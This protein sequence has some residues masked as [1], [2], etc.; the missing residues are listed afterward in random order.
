MYRRKYEKYKAKYLA[1][2]KINVLKGGQ[3]ELPNCLLSGLFNQ[4]KGM[5]WMQSALASLF[6]SDEGR[7]YLWPQIYTFMEYTKDGKG[8]IKP[9]SIRKFS[10]EDPLNQYCLLFEIV[11]RNID[12]AY[13]IDIDAIDATDPNYR[14]EIKRNMSAGLCDE[15][16][17][18]LYYAIDPQFNFYYMTNQH[19]MK[20][21]ELKGG[22]SLHV[23]KRLQLA[24]NSPYDIDEINIEL[25]VTTDAISTLHDRNI[26]YDIL[27]IALYWEE[28]SHAISIFKCNGDFYIFDND[29][30][31]YSKFTRISNEYLISELD[32]EKPNCELQ[33][34][35]VAI[36][37]SILSKIYR[38]AIAIKI[39]HS[40]IFNKSFEAESIIDNS[41]PKGTI[42]EEFKNNLSCSG[43]VYMHAL[44]S[45]NKYNYQVIDYFNIVDVDVS[46]KELFPLKFSRETL[47]LICSSN[48]R[49]LNRFNKTRIFT[50]TNNMYVKSTYRLIE[51]ENIF[52]TKVWENESS[53]QDKY[54]KKKYIYIESLIDLLKT[55]KINDTQ[56]FQTIYKYIKDLPVA[57][58]PIKRVNPFDDLLDPSDESLMKRPNPFDELLGTT[59]VDP[60]DEQLDGDDPFGIVN[61]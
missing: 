17:Y 26:E 53:T 45:S 41:P 12:I 7:K 55:G 28:S 11:R 3:P 58:G 33:M 54:K 59:Q 57:R 38:V 49:I 5:C 39:A 27:D 20:K 60:L 46:A 36:I 21:L 10:N 42:L 22:K 50:L 61:L 43:M 37:M 24:F 15:V 56:D 18:N 34:K 19:D 29:N 51:G 9:K 6:L 2:K 30:N 25:N 48:E 47:E 13:S 14:P 4:F 40:I 16:T 1:Y 35:N 31:Q 52:T 8:Y 23:V 44:S 32:I